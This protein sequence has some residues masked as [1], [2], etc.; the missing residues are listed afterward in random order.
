MIIVE[1]QSSPLIS[2]KYLIDEVKS[3]LK[4]MNKK[5]NFVNNNSVKN[6]KK[7]L[8]T[9]SASLFWLISIGFLENKLKTNIICILKK[10]SSSYKNYNKICLTV[11]DI[12]F[13]EEIKS[14]FA[15]KIVITLLTDPRNPN[16][17]KPPLIP[18]ILFI[19]TSKY[20]EQEEH[21]G[22]AYLPEKESLAGKRIA[23]IFSRLYDKK[24]IPLFGVIGL[25]QKAMIEINR[26]CNLKCALCPVG[27]SQAKKLPQMNTFLFKSIIDTIAPYV[28]K[29]KLYNYGEP[30][31][32]ENL[33]NFIKYTKDSGIEFLEIS[34]N[35]ILLNKDLG[36]KLIDTHLDYLRISIDGINQ[37][38]YAKY[39]HGG[40]V[41]IVWENLQKFRKLRDSMGQKFPI[42]EVQCLAT[43]YTEN[44]IDE[45][46]IKAI[47]AGSD[48][49]RVKTFNAYMSGENKSKEGKCFLPKNKSLS[50]YKDYSNLKYKNKFKL[51]TCKWPF[52]R[53]VILSD[54]TIV[55]CCYDFNGQYV[56]GSIYDKIENNQND[57]WWTNERQKFI[58]RINES[59]NS[60]KMCTRCPVGVPCLAVN[61]NKNL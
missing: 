55:P 7:Y 35:G 20:I 50:R 4:K 10:L 57:W 51:Q 40:F 53:L 60:V 5:I 15:N 24:D 6:K 16:I 22:A 13:A 31:L 56:L 12:K 43:C 37:E 26:S 2:G 25:P 32:H 61:N 23:K 21:S 54:C 11:S 29:V 34:T 44:I 18:G 1:N 8:D 39:R 38:T 36:E 47:N 49:F 30:L 9:H 45:L 19:G 28:W 27:N 52:E 41:D 14:L 17:L 33:P 59:P 58:N 3:T 48:R 46:K 42:I